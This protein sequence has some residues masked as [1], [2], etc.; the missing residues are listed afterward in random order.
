VRALLE[1]VEASPKNVEV[2]VVARPEQGGLRLL[3]DDELEALIKEVEADK[4]AA[5]AAKRRGAGQG[6]AG[7]GAE[8]AA[9]GS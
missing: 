8:G 6:P 4:A 9:E 2:A 7:G 1:S 5:E 3:P